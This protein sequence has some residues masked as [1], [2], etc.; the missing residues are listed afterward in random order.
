MKWSLYTERLIIRKVTKEDAGFFVILLNTPHWLKYIGNRHVTNVE[1]A[2]V[3]LSNG[4]LKSYET[5]GYGFYLVENK[6]GVAIGTCGLV[7]RDFLE[8]V[9]IGFAFLPEFEGQGYGYESAMVIM[10][11]AKDE[12]K[13]PRLVAITTKDNFTSQHLLE[14]LGMKYEQDI[15]FPGEETPLLLFGIQL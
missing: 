3:Y 8:D 14:K 11:F 7:K 13:L 12:L 5:S 2:E 1:E 9:D 15:V 6:E 10:K 4:I